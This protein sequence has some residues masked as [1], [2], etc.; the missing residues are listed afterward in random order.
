MFSFYESNT[1]QSVTVDGKGWWVAYD[2]ESGDSDAFLIP[3]ELVPNG[4][5]NDDEAQ[6]ALEKVLD[7]EWEG[8]HFYA[9]ATHYGYV[10]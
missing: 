9:N 3:E 7:W 1:D 4:I 8:G 5:N 2:T 6:K 10:E